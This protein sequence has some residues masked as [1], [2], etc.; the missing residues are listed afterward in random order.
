MTGQGTRSP[1]LWPSRAAVGFCC[2]SM[3]LQQGSPTPLPLA[4]SPTASQSLEEE[5]EKEQRVFAG[6][7]SLPYKENCL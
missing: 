3:L 6:M 5:R 1:R 4:Y 7:M 2:E